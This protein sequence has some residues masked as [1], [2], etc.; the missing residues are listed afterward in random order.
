MRMFIFHKTEFITD[1]VF[2]YWSIQKICCFQT[3][4][5][6]CS[7][8]QVNVYELLKCNCEATCKQIM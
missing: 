7:V 6:D 5:V 2:E 3:S 4:L 8:G 1:G